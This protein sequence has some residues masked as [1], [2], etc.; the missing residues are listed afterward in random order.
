[1][2]FD[3]PLGGEARYLSSAEYSFPLVSSRGPRGFREQEILR[4]VVFT[5]FGLLGTELNDPSFGEPR[6]SLG[7]G[8][9]ITVPL[10]GVPIALDLAWPIFK[11]DTDRQRQFF[12]SLTK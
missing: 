8:L 10:I 11:E 7:F 5:D 6:L 1:M 2:Q 3:K 9:R 4:G 12:F